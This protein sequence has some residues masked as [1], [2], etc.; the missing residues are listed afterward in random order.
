MGKVL[1][2]SGSLYKNSNTDTLI[3]TIM[4]ATGAEYELIKLSNVNVRPC[5]GCKKCVHREGRGRPKC[6]G[7]R[8]LI[9]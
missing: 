5:I 1:G 8:V 2:I 3:K 4:E 9:R 6:Y 7:L